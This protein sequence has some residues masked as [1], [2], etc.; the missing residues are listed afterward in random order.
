ML[1]LKGELKVL[2]GNL[3][4]IKGIASE[5]LCEDVLG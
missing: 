4:L 2:L 3:G 1:L 5:G